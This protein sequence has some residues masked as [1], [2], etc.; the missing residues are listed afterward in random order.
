MVFRE[1][2]SK[3]EKFKTKVDIRLKSLSKKG[4]LVKVGLK[5]VVSYPNKNIA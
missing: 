2:L 5:E 3:F 4:K 1:I